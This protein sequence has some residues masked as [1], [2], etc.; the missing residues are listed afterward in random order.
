MFSDKIEYCC[1]DVSGK[2]IY[3]GEQN[4]EYFGTG[5]EFGLNVFLKN[6]PVYGVIYVINVS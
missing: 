6:I 2:T 4:S 5:S 3:N 1:W